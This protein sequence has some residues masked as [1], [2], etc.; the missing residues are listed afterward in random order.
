MSAP[1]SPPTLSAAAIQAGA[2]GQL[3]ALLHQLFGAEQ[4]EDGGAAAFADL[5]WSQ[6]RRHCGLHEAALDALQPLQP[7]LAEDPAWAADP[8]HPAWSVLALAQQLAIGYQPELG[9]AGDKLLA[10]LQQWAGRAADDGW[11]ALAELC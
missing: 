10:Q 4:R 11:Q 2:T 8:Q 3:T 9:R 7:K 6:W 1:E 5:F